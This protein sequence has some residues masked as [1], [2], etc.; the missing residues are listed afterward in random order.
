MQLKIGNLE[1][2]LV[3][4]EAVP[5]K[6]E[7]QR[8]YMWA[9]HPA[10]ARRWAN[11]YGSTPRGNSRDEERKKVSTI[12]PGEMPH[13]RKPRPRRPAP[14][15]SWYDQPIPKPMP[16]GLPSPKPPLPS[17]PS[18]GPTVP[19]VKRGRRVSAGPIFP[20]RRRSSFPGQ[21]RGG[22]NWMGGVRNKTN[23]G[24]RT[25]DALMKALQRRL[26]S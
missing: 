14:G 23:R 9:N 26:F 5:F 15:G 17:M 21:G 8:R 22:V 18:G 1:G 7:K 4:G 10:I 25:R 2:F 16:G 13:K 3:T 11:K 20:N 12:L 19:S 6:S 24:N